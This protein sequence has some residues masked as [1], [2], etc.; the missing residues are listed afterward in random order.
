MEASVQGTASAQ[1]RDDVAWLWGIAVESAN[2]QSVWKAELR[3]L[4]EGPD[5]GYER[6]GEAED[7]LRVATSATGGTEP[8]GVLGPGGQARDDGVRVEMAD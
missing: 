2:S 8:P 1:V 4:A 5:V 6:K 7:G 3:R